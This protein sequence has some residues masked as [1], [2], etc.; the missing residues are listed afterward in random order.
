VLFDRSRR[1]GPP[2]KQ[3]TDRKIMYLH[4][5]GAA[6]NSNPYAQIMARY[7]RQY[8]KQP[9]THPASSVTESTIRFSPEIEGIRLN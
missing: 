2:P 3:L 8:G 7:V 6:A 1:N 9:V 4:E 5:G